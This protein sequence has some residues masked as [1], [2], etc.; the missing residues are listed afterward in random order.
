MSLSLPEHR[1]ARERYEH[2]GWWDRSTLSELVR[3]T[4]AQR[5][6][7]LAVVDLEGRRR[8]TYAELDRDAG[9]V[10]GHLVHLGVAPGDVV[11]VQ[12]PNWYE[13]VALALGVLRAGAVL[14][15]MVTIYRRRELTHMVGVAG[16]KVLIT[17]EVYRGFDHAAMGR[18]LSAEYPG[19]VHLA[20]PDPTEAPDV[21]GTW[22][23][24]LPQG[25]QPVPRAASFVSEVLF[26]SGTEAA[27]KAIMHT[28]QT[29]NAGVRTAASSLGLTE[30]DIVWMPSP[31]GHSTGLNFGVRMAFVHGL[32]LV[33]QDKWDPAIA[34]RLVQAEGCTYTVAATTFLSDLV[35]HCEQHAVALP[36]LRLF[37]S[38][39]AP[40]PPDLVAAADRHQMTVLRLYGS[41]EVL[42]ATW[43]RPGAT[44]EQRRH[45]D[46]IPLDGV[47]LEVRDDSGRAVI[48]SP[49][50][51]LVRGPACTVGFLN[52]PVRT[53]QTID[54]EGWVSSGD[55]GVLDADGYL[56][57][58]GRKKEI[59]I[60][61]GMNVAPREVE[62][63]I[64]S[65]PGVEAVAVVGL[66][67]ERLGEIGCACLVLRPGTELTLP[68]LVAE[69]KE[70]GL[71]NYKL[72]E[73]LAVFAELPRTASGK[74][75][76]HRLLEALT[77][78]SGSLSGP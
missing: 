34:A 2:A 31:I 9:R 7:H 41:T 1:A 18:D 39:G 8:R 29:A 64:A 70:Q 58:V 68:D 77:E 63:L 24:T 78:R 21:F 67:D 25:P 54:P 11:A 33:L 22:L 37:G 76:K 45:T 43:T 23:A 3:A 49:G 72:P 46:G 14:N 10:A 62:D 12:L 56:T 53:A 5:P 55:L 61:G 60:R 28:E 19:L 32:T 48:G 59:I 16:T 27:P 57:I 52:D 65:L 74:I 75:Q 47:E 44:P 17:P 30:T 66:P 4:A 36:S 71:A 40:V 6:S 15:P 51:I 26:S 38:G 50:E 20:V 13:H 42:V 69:L 73:R 35:R